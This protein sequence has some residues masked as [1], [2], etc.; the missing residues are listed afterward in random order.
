MRI[1]EADSFAEVCSDVVIRFKGHGA[2]QGRPGAL[3]A[4]RRRAPGYEAS[5]YEQG[6]DIFCEVYDLAVKA[7]RLFPAAQQSKGKFAKYEDIDA[8]QCMSYL[9]RVLPGQGTGIKRQILNWVIFWHYLLLPG[10]HAHRDAIGSAGTSSL[11]A[12]LFARS[13]LSRSRVE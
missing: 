3:R 13:D 1:P 10:R 7:I 8:D 4:F 11:L 2:Y 12:G 6:L 9:E 5:T